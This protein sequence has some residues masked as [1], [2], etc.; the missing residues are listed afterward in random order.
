[1]TEEQD[2][3]IDQTSKQTSE[4]SENDQLFLD[5]RPEEK[6]MDPVD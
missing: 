6:G 3:L 2:L 5:T 1:M 4:V